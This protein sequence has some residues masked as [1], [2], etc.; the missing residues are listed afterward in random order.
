MNLKR[1]LAAAAFAG[2][3]VICARAGGAWPDRSEFDVSVGWAHASFHSRLSKDLREQDGVRLEPRYSFA[4]WRERP[5]VR[6]GF[7]LGLS[8]FYEENDSDASE[9]GGFGDGG[10]IF[11]PADQ[12]EQLTLIVPE[13]QLSWR[14]PIGPQQR[15]DHFWAEAGVGVAPVIGNYRNGDAAFGELFTDQSRWDCNVGVRPFLRAAWQRKNWL[16]GAEA[17]YL[18]TNLD[19]GDGLNGDVQEIYAGLFIGYRW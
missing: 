15:S 17:S 10:F 4:L 19:F 18:W 9:G 14:Q 1:M 8:T 11:E 12:F 2:V 13:F 16:L 6:L 3:V 5:E 7:G